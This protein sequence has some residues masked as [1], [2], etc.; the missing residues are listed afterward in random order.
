MARTKASPATA[1]AAP[2]TEEKKTTKRTATAKTAAAKT[3]AA[4]KAVAPHGASTA[5]KTTTTRKAV[6][7]KTTAKPSPE[8]RYQMI[9]LAAYFIAEKNG[10]QGCTSDYWKQ[11][12]AQI[13]E[14]LGE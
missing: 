10:F 12:E 11:A 13:A 14:Q 7:K 6:S 8:E 1:K 5:T 9:E 3:P 2:V 4:K